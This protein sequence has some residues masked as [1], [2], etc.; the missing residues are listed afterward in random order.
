MD[1]TGKP[2]TKRALLIGTT[3]CALLTALVSSNVKSGYVGV[4]VEAEVTNY[5]A[6]TLVWGAGDRDFL[7]MDPIPADS[8]DAA[9]AHYDVEIAATG[10][11]NPAAVMPA[12]SF[13]GIPYR[14]GGEQ[15]PADSWQV[16][17][18]AV[19]SKT[20]HLPANYRWNGWAAE[21]LTL[22]LETGP[23]GGI[24]I[25]N[26]GARQDR[27]DT[28][29]EQ[30]GSLRLEL[31]PTR[32]L[33]AFCARV[34]RPSLSKLKLRI[35]NLAKDGVQRIL[36]NSWWPVTIESQAPTRIGELELTDVMDAAA[37]DQPG[38]GVP[39]GWW[40]N[41]PNLITRGN[42]A[43]NGAVAWSLAPSND[44]ETRL[45]KTLSGDYASETLEVSAQ[46]SV[47]EPDAF[48]IAVT[49]TAEGKPY[50]HSNTY[51]TNGRW[52]PVQFTTQLPKGLDKDSLNVRLIV[53]TKA[54]VPVR[55]ASVTI[56]HGEG[57]APIHW[58][59]PADTPATVG[60]ATHGT[61]PSRNANGDVSIPPPNAIECGRAA[62]TGAAFVISAL[63]LALLL[64]CVRV[65][66]RLW[67]YVPETRPKRALR[68][69]AINL[70][71]L[72]ASCIVGLVIVECALRLFYFGALTSIDVRSY[73]SAQSHPTRGWALRPNNRARTQYID[74]DVLV[75]TNSKG[76]RDREHAY[77]HPNGVYRIAIL[78]DS[79]MEAYQVDMAQ[80]LPDR[81]NRALA[82]RGVEVINFGVRGYG[83]AQEFLT[84]TEEAVRYT[85]DLVLLAYY[86]LNDLVDNSRALTRLQWGDDNWRTA[87]RPYPAIDV[88]GQLAMALIDPLKARRAVELDLAQN[89]LW[90]GKLAD[91]GFLQ[92]SA[93]Y[94]TYRFIRQA[95]T[96]SDTSDF[97]P[98]IEYGAIMKDFVSTGAHD[99]G[100][101]SEL[102]SDSWAV[103]ARC[104]EAFHRATREHGAKFAVFSIPA[105]IEVDTK[106][107]AALQKKFPS[108]ALDV[109]KPHAQLES[110]AAEDRFD[111]LNLLPVFQDAYAKRNAPLYHRYMDT[112][113]NAA[114][115][116]VATAALIEFLDERHLVPPAHGAP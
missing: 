41:A 3:V 89:L 100:S 86:P 42:G 61:P 56:R 17:K 31:A 32:I 24:A 30:P 55:I 14:R 49:G 2:R 75:T 15:T 47:A 79:F 51:A 10:E 33:R 40:A 71:L 80:A 77:E 44:D 23:H 72:V 8:V 7:P 28:Y 68:S 4:R 18:R 109:A 60:N 101:Y 92:N 84:L 57:P 20:G 43:P 73:V 29:S 46:L 37:F 26:D 98:N 106:L 1:T 22:V 91:R 13:S 63:A 69:A 103:T 62:T 58:A 111:Q 102:W 112:H 93:T 116:A 64:G 53:S 97:D 36:V 34:P 96:V 113:W 19:V 83:T 50:A 45:V 48:T 70:T 99:P 110:L 11:S 65:I 81:L 90:R 105:K 59:I 67:R 27:I 115:H 39:N 104:I 21:G 114:G 88:H 94:E 107:Q 108:I 54:K 66:S 6:P 52:D 35:P 5:D 12:I 76:L 9:V 16:D 95:Y 74:Y 78:G 87:S 85:P 82:D 38:N 25:V